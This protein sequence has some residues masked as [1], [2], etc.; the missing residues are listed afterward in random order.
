MRSRSAWL[1]VCSVVLLAGCGGG[2]DNTFTTTRQRTTTTSAPTIQSDVADQLAGRSDEI[3]RQLDAGDICG[4]AHTADRLRTEL[5]AAI[6]AGSIP[7]LYLED[8]SSS[9]N[10]LQAQLQCSPPA[11]EDDHGKRKGHDKEK[12][13]TKHDGG[14]D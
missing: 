5:T 12:K 11:E 4:A 14:D 1:T 10:E 2:S 8:L 9:V 3:A 13:R 7:A 6:N